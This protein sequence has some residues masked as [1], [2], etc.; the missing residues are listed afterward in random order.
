MKD[1]L[2]QNIW[3]CT[4]LFLIEHLILVCTIPESYSKGRY[5]VESS[6]QY[7]HTYRFSFKGKHEHKWRDFQQ[8]MCKLSSNTL[9]AYEKERIYLSVQ[10]PL[11]P[12]ITC[13]YVLKRIVCHCHCSSDNT[14]K[15]MTSCKKATFIALVTIA[16]VMMMGK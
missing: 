14:S 12:K 5:V 1:Y 7:R 8:E 11:V 10:H 6:L 2:V 3:C 9:I 13:E 4:R 15:C 16:S